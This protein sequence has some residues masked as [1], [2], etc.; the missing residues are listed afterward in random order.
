ME[1]L[2]EVTLKKILMSTLVTQI[3]QINTLSTANQVQATSSLKNIIEAIAALKEAKIC[4]ISEEEINNWLAKAQL[5][6]LLERV[7]NE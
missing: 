1:E 5:N 4:I 3:V 2:Q 7:S 6:N